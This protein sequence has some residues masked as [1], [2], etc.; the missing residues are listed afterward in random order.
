MYRQRKN[1]KQMLDKGRYIYGMVINLT[2][3]AVAEIAGL[4]GYD[5]VRLDCEHTPFD[6]AEIRSFIRAADSVG[7][8]VIVRLPELGAITGLLDFGAAGFM[9]PHV[10]SAEEARAVVQAAKYYPVGLRGY[11]DGARAQSYGAVD[12]EEYVKQA[13]D[14]IVLMCQI[15]DKY[16]IENMEEIIA[17]E[18]IDGICT[19]PGD[20]S[21]SLGITGLICDPRVK[22]VEARILATARKYGKQ[23]YMSAGGEERARELATMGV[24][25]FSVCYDFRAICEAAGSKLALFK[26]IFEK[27]G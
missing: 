8:P 20:I 15:E 26:N 3:P 22:Q 1:I 12:M 27:Q 13:N 18:G 23:M 17:V 25:A 2:D 11:S 21:Q 10:R 14:E 5:F 4:A 24:R 6:H 16:G 19:G 9:I 7:I